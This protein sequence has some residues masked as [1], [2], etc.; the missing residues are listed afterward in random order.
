[1]QT[2]AMRSHVAS[3]PVRRLHL[4][5]VQE[6]QVGREVMEVVMRDAIL[7]LAATLGCI[8]AHV[9]LLLMLEP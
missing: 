4:P 9:V 2:Q 5:Q 3:S 7:A 8:A 6:R 1:M